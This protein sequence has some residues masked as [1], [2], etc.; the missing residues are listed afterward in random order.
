MEK[1][2]K[3]RL[4]M[5]QMGMRSSAYWVAWGVYAFA[6]SAASTAVLVGAGHAARFSFFTNSAFVAPV[7]LFGLTSLSYAA[8]A[9]L[10]SSLVTTSKSAQQLGYSVAL[11][12]FLFIS[13]VGSGSGI[14]LS[15]L[16]SSLLRPWMRATRDALLLLSPALAYTFVLYDI[17]A[18]AGSTLDVS[19][20]RVI[21]GPGFALGDIT[22]AAT[23]DV[24]GYK[25]AVPS[26][27]Y[28][29]GVIA[30]DLVIALVV[31]IYLDAVLPGPQGSPLHPLCC[32]GA[33]YSTRAAPR[34]APLVGEDEGVVSERAHAR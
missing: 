6:F 26:P 11:V 27:A 12:S 30:L 18:R 22:R 34:A 5:R 25:C 29:L 7:A 16:Y 24:F 4:G 8:F 14:L 2:E 3:L 20:Q 19:S 1:E 17:E 32:L 9:V 28:H 15:L 13:I 10:L 33:R 23:V 21:S 31:G